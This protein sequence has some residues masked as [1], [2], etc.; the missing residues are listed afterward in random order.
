MKTTIRFWSYLAQFVLEWE[1]FQTKV[2]ERVK[3]HII[4]AVTCFRKDTVEKY[5]RA[6]QAADDNTAHVFCMVGTSG[7][8][9]T[10]RIYHTHCF[11]SATIIARTRPSI[12]LYV[13]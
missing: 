13:H 6:R 9:L 3:T 1:M 8:K 2:V 12:T 10:L 4:C 5:Y 11:S 7:Y